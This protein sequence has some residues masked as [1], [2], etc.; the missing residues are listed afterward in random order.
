MFVLLEAMFLLCL[1]CAVKHFQRQENWTFGH[2]LVNNCLT[3]QTLSH[4]SVVFRYKSINNGLLSG[5]TVFFSLA[6]SYRSKLNRLNLVMLRM[7]YMM[8]LFVELNNGVS[9][10]P[11]SIFPA[12][13]GFPAKTKCHFIWQGAARGKWPHRWHPSQDWKYQIWVY[14]GNRT[15]GCPHFQS[16]HL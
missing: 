9:D 8:Y 11:C 4:S 15:A 5:A 1:E 16:W 7:F 3:V 14:W 2:L 10:W 6:W 13:I 12:F